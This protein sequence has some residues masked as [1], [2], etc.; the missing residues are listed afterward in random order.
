MVA[1]L[2]FKGVVDDNLVKYAL[3]LGYRAIA[4]RGASS[5]GVLEGIKLVPRYELKRDDVA[6][7]RGLRGLKVLLVRSSD[8]LK[9]YPKLAGSI[10]AV[11]IDF[12]QLDEVNKGFLRRL[13][14]LGVP[15]EVEFLELV[16]RLL[17]G[18]PLDY[19]YLI[20]RLYVRKKIRI[21]VCSG[22]TDLSSMVHPTAMFALVSVLGVPEALAAKAIFKLPSELISN[23]T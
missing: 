4:Y 13:I 22:A 19:Y 12:T 6:R 8:D 3:R 5:A 18:Y 7:S 10:D 17:N 21:Y 2:C 14:G 1:D 20:L 16:N 9:A 15:V 11:K 23:V